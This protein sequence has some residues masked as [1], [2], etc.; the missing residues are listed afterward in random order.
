MAMIQYVVSYADPIHAW[1]KR[2]GEASSSSGAAEKRENVV[3]RVGIT[4]P[5]IA[6]D[7]R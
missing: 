6:W 1:P 5:T 7:G 4:N 3:G 2:E